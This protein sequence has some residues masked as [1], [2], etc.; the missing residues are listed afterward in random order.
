MI[1]PVGY[2]K[3]WRELATKPIWLKSTAQ[4]QV[5]LITL[6]LMA[7]Y[8]PNKWEWQGKQYDLQEG[9]FITSAESIIESCGNSVSRQNVRTT[10]V[11]L[12]KLDFLTYQTTKTGTLVTIANWAL[13]QGNGV[14]L[15]NDLTI[16]QPTA[17]HHLTTKEEYKESKK[18]KKQINYTEEFEIFYALYPN[19]FNKQQSFK[20]WNSC[21]KSDTIDNIMLATRKYIEEINAKNT[22]PEYIKRSTNFIGTEHFYKGYLEM[23][24]QTPQL[25]L[26]PVMQPVRQKS[27][28]KREE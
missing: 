18:E 13:Y 24:Q 14:E 15:T 17:N 7:Q 16:S 3:L 20:N 8:K 9:Q 5:I 12:S 27:N 4:Q 6:L 2:I 11:R 1:Q 25:S 19:P 10:L 26:L 23:A 22:K 21:L 28:Y